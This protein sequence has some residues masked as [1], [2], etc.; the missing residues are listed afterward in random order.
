MISED[1]KV[2]DELPLGLLEEEGELKRLNGMVS[3]VV[4]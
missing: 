2:R 3:T 1:G 4:G